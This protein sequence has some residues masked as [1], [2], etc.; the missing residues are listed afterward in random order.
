M[1]SRTRRSKC[2]TGSSP[3]SE[4]ATSS[5]HLVGSCEGS[6]LMIA[7]H[8]AA[9]SHPLFES[10]RPA[11]PPFPLFQTCLRCGFHA[12]CSRPASRVGWNLSDGGFATILLFLQLEIGTTS[13][14]SA[15]GGRKLRPEEL[16]RLMRRRFQFLL[17]LQR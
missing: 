3:Y 12:D 11:N 6:D 15:C 9:L 17:L 5:S 4:S 2:S 16:V 8:T 7:S 13:A 1:H 10:P 14:A